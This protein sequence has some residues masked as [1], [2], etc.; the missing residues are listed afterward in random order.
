VRLLLENTPQIHSAAGR[1]NSQAHDC[2]KGN[3]VRFAGFEHL[4]LAN[5]LFDL[6]LALHE[7]VDRAVSARCGTKTRR[8]TFRS[9]GEFPS[10]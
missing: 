5:C 1:A 7:A 4:E 3:W 2:P 9:Q 6:I 10:P 8:D